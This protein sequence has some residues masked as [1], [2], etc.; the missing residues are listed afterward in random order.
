LRVRGLHFEGK[1]RGFVNLARSWY[2]VEP[3]LFTIPKI[4]G[5]GD[6]LQLLRGGQC[7]GGCGFVS[8]QGLA[9]PYDAPLAARSG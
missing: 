6:N 9:A 5:V 1:K 8:A 7:F 3:A 4:I 2:R